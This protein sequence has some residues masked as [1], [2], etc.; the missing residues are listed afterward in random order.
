MKK[1]QKILMLSATILTTTSFAA[2]SCKSVAANE[3]TNLQQLSK[4]KSLPK[5]SVNLETLPQKHSTNPFKDISQ[6][7]F[8]NYINWCYNHEITTRYTPTTYNPNGYVNRGEMAT[9]LYRFAG[10]PQYIP[11]FNVFSDITHQNNKNHILWL[12]ATTI[13]RGT[14]SHYDPNSNVTRG[15]MAAFLHRMAVVSG[16]APAAKKYTSN[17]K[18]VKNHMFTNDIGWLSSENITTGYTPTIF[19][20]DASITRGE[21]AAFLY[22]FYNVINKKDKST[23]NVKDTTI[24]LNSTWKAQDNFVNATDKSGKKVTFAQITFSGQVYTT[25]EGTYSITYKYNKINKIAKVTVKN[26]IKRN[27][28][29]Q[30]SKCNIWRS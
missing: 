27:N 19:K 10:T 9:F 11:P 15:Q 3:V 2:T 24:G 6:S 28:S 21:M 12:S 14:G 26:H 13:T 25:K 22:R 7:I 29:Y 17:F 18:D 5:I 23:L 8:K 16:N 1:H 4:D 30:R 20:P